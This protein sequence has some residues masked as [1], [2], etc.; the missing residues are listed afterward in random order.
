[1]RL[2]DYDHPGPAARVRIWLLLCALS[3]AGFGLLDGP[4]GEPLAIGLMTMP[5]VGAILLHRAVPDGDTV[6][7]FLGSL[8]LVARAGAVVAGL[9]TALLLLVGLAGA[10]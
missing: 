9:L 5:V 3:G 4:P 2:G 7:G 8:P 10:P 6:R 1:M